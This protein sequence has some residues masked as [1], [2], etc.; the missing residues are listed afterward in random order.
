MGFLLRLGLALAVCGGLP[1]YARDDEL[2]RVLEHTL[3]TARPEARRSAVRKLAAIATPKAWACVIGALEDP[4]SMVADEAQLRVAA[5]DDP[6]V[7]AELLGRSGLRSK[8][9][10]VRLRCAEAIGRSAIDVDGTE[11]VRLFSSDPELTRTLLWSIERLALSGRLAGERGRIEVALASRARRERDGGVRAAAVMALATLEGSPGA[12]ASSGWIQDA[13]GHRDSRVRCAALLAARWLRAETTLALTRAIV[14]DEAWSVRLVAVENLERLE[15]RAA[16]RTLVQRLEIE[17]APRVADRLVAALRSL[18]GLKYRRDPRPWRDWAEGLD[19]DWRPGEPSTE[20]ARDARPVTRS[21]GLAGLPVI[22]PRITF[23]IDFSGSMWMPMSD[24]RIPKERVDEQ[25]RTVLEGF[26]RETH[27][28]IIPFANEPAPWRERLV[29]ARSNHVKK[30]LAD[31]ERCNLRG[32]GNFFDAAIVALADPDVETVTT[33]TDGLPTGG[34]HSNLELIVPLLIER[35]RFRRV[36][37]DAILVDC[38]MRLRR[39]WEALA[40]SSDG[41]ALAVDHM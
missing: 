15:S 3:E 4:E 16:V 20:P 5:I 35:N 28:N 6:R 38:P 37:F 41:R 8:R 7:Q 39:H 18:S 24:G 26:D 9:E 17:T 22:S 33:L 23:L 2:V 29:P 32:R 31:F 27:F 36:R 30:A 1:R 34:I 10:L 40:A 14:A 11:L 21:E 13:C 12:P 25:M 19:A